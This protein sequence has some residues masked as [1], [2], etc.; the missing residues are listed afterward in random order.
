MRFATDNSKE[1]EFLFYAPK[2]HFVTLYIYNDNVKNINLSLPAKTC[3]YEISYISCSYSYANVYLFI[4][5]QM[6]S[7]T[8]LLTKTTNYSP[9]RL[10]KAFEGWN[11]MKRLH[12]IYSA[13]RA[14]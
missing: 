10:P 3:Y 8:P 7:S 13:S 12:P 6:F 9:G 14:R 1:P 5:N 4:S 2:T 11:L